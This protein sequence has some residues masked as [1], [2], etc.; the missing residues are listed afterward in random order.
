[1][2]TVWLH[3]GACVDPAARRHGL[4]RLLL[5][6]LRFSGVD[7]RLMFSHTYGRKP[8]VI[9]VCLHLCQPDVFAVPLSRQNLQLLRADYSVLLFVCPSTDALASVLQL[10]WWQPT[11]AVSNAESSSCA[12]TNSMYRYLKK[13]ISILGCIR[14]LMLAFLALVVPYIVQ[15]HPG[16]STRWMD[17]SGLGPLVV[18][19]LGLLVSLLC[20]SCAAPGRLTD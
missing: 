13:R 9:C 14:V 15:S 1:M 12:K 6:L 8:I 11:S 7:K 19:P 17:M 3:H 5:I 2:A 18:I 4:V 10:L 16:A 20:L